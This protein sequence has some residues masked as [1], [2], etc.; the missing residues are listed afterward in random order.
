MSTRPLGF[1]LKLERLAAVVVLA[2]LV[3]LWMVLDL[4]ATVPRTVGA[5]VILVS[6]GIAGVPALRLQDPAMVVLTALLVS[7][8]VDI[9]VA[10]L[11]T[12]VWGF[13]WRLCAVILVSFVV[14][15]AAAQPLIRVR[16]SR[17]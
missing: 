9:A 1:A 11:V 10:Q 8:V 7:V 15:V 12:Y 4:G 2:D 3:S 17:L 13:S 6:P 14:V 5:I 16:S